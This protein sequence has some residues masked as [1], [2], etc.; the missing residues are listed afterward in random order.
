MWFGDTL[1]PDIRYDA[2]TK[3]DEL[4]CRFE[5]YSDNLI[6]IDAPTRKQAGQIANYCYE[7]EQHGLLIY[8]TGKKLSGYAWQNGR[9]FGQQP[10][11]LQYFPVDPPRHLAVGD[12]V[13]VGALDIGGEEVHIAAC[14]Q[15][16]D[17]PSCV[18]GHSLGGSRSCR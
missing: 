18:K 2:A 6:A 1:Q 17:E 4:K 8:E 14:F 15:V 5:F 7:K 3:I 12:A 10:Q 9:S 16:A 11:F 13:G